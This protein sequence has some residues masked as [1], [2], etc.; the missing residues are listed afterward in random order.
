MEELEQKSGTENY[1]AI[2]QRALDI[3]ELIHISGGEVGRVEDTVSRICY[4]YGAKRVDIL[5]ITSSIIVTAVFQDGDA[6]TQTRRITA[7]ARNMT[8][9]DALNKLSREVCETLPPSD[10]IEKKLRSIRKMRRLPWYVML[11]A[12]MAVA[13]G[14][15]WFF[16]GSFRDGL[17]ALLVTFAVFAAEII[18]SHL[19]ANKIVFYL[20]VSVVSGAVSVGTVH[21]GV[22]ENVN[23]IMIGVIMLLIP[24][25]AIT[26][27]LENL[28]TGDTISGLLQF[29]ESL[30][31]TGVI[32]MGFAIS[33]YVFG[34]YEML[35]DGTGYINEW[36]K[37]ATA[38]YA[39]CGYAVVFGVRKPKRL[40]TVTIGGGITQATFSLM[41][42]TG[43]HYSICLMVAAAIGSIYSQI[44]ARVMKT[45]A[46]VY[47]IPS[48]IPLVPG[49]ALY[50]TM[51][52]ALRGD[53]V[54]F[55]EKG[56]ETLVSALAIAFGMMMIMHLT[57]G[58]ML[59]IR[60]KRLKNNK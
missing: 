60:K 19:R 8:M 40:I 34:G 52:R 46:T 50:Y 18:R 51:S 24:G 30:I 17:A 26:S 14:F 7:S 12:E 27:A 13:S 4:A 21:I 42:L 29:C 23:A 58:I 33:T 2:L 31:T 36:L 57:G 6:I 43:V 25:I 32:A 37:L 35:N 47:T 39:S 53:V 11:I 1:S 16:G 38:L 45:P 49:S 9:L 15:T 48:I 59:A 3:G 41:M 44:M 28:M 10:D 55:S 5:T 54:G 22:G 56:I 20:L